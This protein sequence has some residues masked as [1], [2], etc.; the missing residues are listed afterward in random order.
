MTKMCTFFTTAIL[1]TALHAPL[2]GAAVASSAF[3][4]MDSAFDIGRSDTEDVVY[5]R[6]E[7]VLQGQ[8]LNDKIGLV[9]SYGTLSLPLRRCAGLS[10]EATRAHADAVVT[11]NFNRFTGIV[12]DHVFQFRIGS[13]GA[14]VP[15]RKETI[16]FL[17]LKKT[18]NETAFLQGQGNPDLFVMANGD[19]LT[20]KSVEQT[21]EL[22]TDYAKVP[23]P[24]G[25]IKEVRLLGDRDITAVVTKIKGDPV[26]GTWETSELS[27]K[28]EI[29][30]DLSAVYKDQ[31]ARI[32]VGRARELAPAQFGSQPPV[33]GDVDPALLVGMASTNEPTITLDLGNKAA[34]KLALI[35]AGKF[36]M[37]SLGD[38]PGRD[39]DEGPQRE[40]VVSRPFYM[41]VH[42]VTQGQYEAVVGSNPSRFV[43]AAK[44]VESVSWDE[45]VEFCRRLSR[46]THQAVALPTE[47]QWEYACR[48]GL[49]TRFGFGEDDR[50]LATFARYSQGAEAGTA[51]VGSKKPSAWGLFDMHGNVWEWCGDWYAS[52]YVNAAAQ[53]PPG[54]LSGQWRVLRGGSWVNTWEACRCAARNKSAPDVRY[55]GIGFRVVV[56][57]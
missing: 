16:A 20:G 48:A 5:F 28:L 14:E 41:G 23:V 9:T 42:E 56:N 15:L 7:D 4:R 34:M 30:Q 47:A 24:F 21:V 37:G 55:N 25:E 45:A 44:P 33:P 3:P 8:L 53:D 12:T 11:V 22:R 32:F 43:D 26:R 35:P 50:Q 19:L 2:L 36:L 39:E 29:G 1:L 27:L 46:R 38:E 52:S 13:S 18:P 54:P 10:F 49:K 57:L 6:S 17:V 31:F 51:A 40:V